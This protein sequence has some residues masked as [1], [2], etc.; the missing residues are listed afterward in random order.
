MSGITSF[1]SPKR[2]HLKEASGWFAAGRS[3]RQAMMLLSDGAFKLMVYLCLQAD[4]STGT[5]R[6]THKQ[7]AIAL[8]KSKRAIGAY[9]EELC[10]KEVC[11]VLPGRNQYAPSCFQIADD[12]WPYQRD[13]AVFPSEAGHYVA[14]VRAAFLESGCSHGQFSPADI[15]FARILESRG[16]PVS[17]VRDAILIGSCRKYL[18]WLNGGRSESI[19]SLQ[20]FEPLIDEVSRQPI[21]DD[22]REYLRKKVDQLAVSWSQGV[23]TQQ[24]CPREQI[25]ADGLGSESVQ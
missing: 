14:A 7:L 18:S 11:V 5:L 1:P 3:F 2:I 4:R 13:L 6:I 16:I 12:Y 23:L 15:R 17:I 10:Q 9:V 19:G 20:Y 8:G 22:Y 24:T 25:Q 21:T